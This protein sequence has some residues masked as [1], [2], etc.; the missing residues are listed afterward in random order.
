MA[1]ATL[2][3]RTISIEEVAF[4]L[5]YTEASTFYRSFRRWTGKTPRQYRGG[6]ANRGG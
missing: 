3:E 6:A 1:I 2:R 4:I 5:G